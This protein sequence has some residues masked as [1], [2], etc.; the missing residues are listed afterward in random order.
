[1]EEFT[2]TS[3]E[4]GDA[5]DQ[6]LMAFAASRRLVRETR[7]AE[8]EASLAASAAA[9]VDDAGRVDFVEV[10]RQPVNDAVKV[11]VDVVD[12]AA[13][14]S[15]A[16]AGTD[17]SASEKPVVESDDYA[18]KRVAELAAQLAAG[19]DYKPS[20][21]IIREAEEARKINIK[22]QQS[23]QK[24]KEGAAAKKK[25]AA[26]AKDTVADAKGA[27]PAVKQAQ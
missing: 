9:M 3:T 19:T 22:A 6:E 25:P 18:V 2:G 23:A 13:E 15:E 10:V 1:M 20:A 7:E 24:A 26:A 12:G 11:D 14:G 5:Y 16:T 27:K 8:L 4:S 21:E 17:A